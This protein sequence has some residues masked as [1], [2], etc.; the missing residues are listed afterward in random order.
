MT[1]KQFT[2]F[3]FVLAGSMAIAACNSNNSTS[4]P[5]KTEAKLGTYSTVSCKTMLGSNEYPPNAVCGYLNTPEKHAVGEDKGSNKRFKVAVMK[6]PAINKDAKPDPIVFLTGGPGS[7]AINMAG[8]LTQKPMNY[9]IE[10]RDLYLVDPRGTGYSQPSY[11]C[12]EFNGM[13]PTSAQL[14]ACRKRLADKGVD[15]AAFQSVQLAN[16]II[17]LRK[18]LKIDSWNLYGI[19]YGTRLA[20]TIV[21]EDSSGIH[22]VVMDGVFP[23][24]VNGISDAPWGYYYNLN[25]VV[26]ACTNTDWCEGHKVHVMIEKAISDLQN[27]GKPEA[28][29]RYISTI[30]ENMGNSGVIQYI[31]A[32]DGDLSYAIEQDEE[33]DEE[34]FYAPMA[35]SIV[36]SEEYPFLGQTALSEP[37]KKLW[38]QGTQIVVD[39]MNHMGFSK[40][41]CKV[42]DVKPAGDI[43]TQPVSNHLPTLVLNGRNDEQT[44]PEWGDLALKHKF[45]GFR[46]TN[47]WGGHVQLLSDNPHRKCI[48]GIVTNFLDEYYNERTNGS[49]DPTECVSKIPKFTYPMPTAEDQE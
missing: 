39:K 27:M 5:V 49:I 17:M 19:S 38:S 14:A 16:D 42:W 20:E 30:S 41:N 46:A 9:L 48:D 1:P 28:A 21:R 47:N 4:K 44:A 6:I 35:F 15:F 23:I 37:D 11:T 33:E 2:R 18:A 8:E 10:D 25:R 12:S 3:A 31:N 13:V 29:A 34:V 32:V 7:S 45:A 26:Q 43:E 36:C 40:E 22:S 24:E